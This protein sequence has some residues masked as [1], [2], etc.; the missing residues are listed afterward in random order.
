MDD[1]KHVGV[2]YERLAL[3]LDDLV[4]RQHESR[5]PTSLNYIIN[6][7][8]NTGTGSQLRHKIL[9]SGYQDRHRCGPVSAMSLSILP[10]CAFP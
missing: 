4:V 6:L 8:E 9:C 3:S 10:E 1:N 5:H 2:F 7:V